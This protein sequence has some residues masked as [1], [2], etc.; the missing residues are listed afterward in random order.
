MHKYTLPGLEIPLSVICLGAS[1][2]GSQIPESDAFALLDDF[3]E[4][5]GT[6]ADTAHVYADWLPGGHGAS[7]TTLGKWRRTRGLT[8]TFAIG[9]K[10]G[11]PRLETMAISRLTPDDIATD[12]GESLERLGAD[13]IDLYWLHRDNEN[14]P[15]GEFI[16]ALNAHRDAGRIGVLGASNWSA[17]RVSAANEYASAHGK[18]GFVATQ[19]KWSLKHAE[20]AFDAATGARAMTNSELV[21][22]RAMGVKVVPYSAQAG[23]FFAKPC[24]PSESAINRERWRRAQELALAMDCTPN[25]IALAYV[26]NHKCGGA[27]IC[28]PR[29]L[30]QMEDTCKAASVTLTGELLRYLRGKPTS[31]SDDTV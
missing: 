7:E 26:L 16:D 20:Q 31:Y 12:I 25:Q 9:T 15:V 23:G 6:F 3:A 2:F 8:Q 1:L 21:D 5:G 24:R 19:I 13:K 4:R 29:T 18:A 10:G 11:H 28:A 27:A 30:G 22:Y 17:A 14:V